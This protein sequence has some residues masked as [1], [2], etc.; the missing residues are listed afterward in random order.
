[1]ERMGLPQAKAEPHHQRQEKRINA[2]E[3][4]SANKGGGKDRSV[5]VAAQ[6]K[7]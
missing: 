3:Q 2:D 4:A 6:A 5:A 7:Q 1:M